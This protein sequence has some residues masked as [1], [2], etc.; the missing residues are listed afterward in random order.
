M[1]QPQLRDRLDHIQGTHQF[2]EQSVGYVSVTQGGADGTV[3][4]KDLQDADIGA[5]FQQM[6]GKAVTQGMHGDPLRQTRLGDDLPQN[7]VHCGGSNMTLRFLTREQ[8]LSL[9]PGCLVVLAQQNQKALSQHDVAVFFT[10]SRTDM[11]AHPL[12]VNIGDAKSAYFRNPE[13][14][15]IGG[16][17]DGFIFN[18]ADGLKNP[19][20]L[21]P[22]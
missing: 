14:G 5:G 8:V 4:Q 10:F 13:T 12:T 2:L 17:N 7:L 21:L 15:G 3:T 11:D 22:G 6:S 1:G 18:R 9:R 20:E 16:G 19:E